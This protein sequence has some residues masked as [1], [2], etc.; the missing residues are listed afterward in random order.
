MLKITT[1]TKIADY[2]FNLYPYVPITNDDAQYPLVQELLNKGVVFGAKLIYCLYTA[3]EVC[4]IVYAKL[5]KDNVPK[6]FSR[7]EDLYKLFL[8]TF[9]NQ[10]RA[11]LTYDSPYAKPYDKQAIVLEFFSKL[12][13]Y[14]AIKTFDFTYNTNIK[15][16]YNDYIKEFTNTQQGE[17]E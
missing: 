10:W 17:I 1:T 11:F 3:E 2:G 4:D 7:V 14:N 6:A 8:P 16:L 12:E 15:Q 9:Y 5:Q 13:W